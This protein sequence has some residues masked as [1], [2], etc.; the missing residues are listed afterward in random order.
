MILYRY[1][2]KIVNNEVYISEI[3]AVP[4][5]KDTKKFGDVKYDISDN[6][7]IIY[8]Y[9]PKWVVLKNHRDAVVIMHAF[10]TS[11]QYRPQSAF[12]KNFTKGMGVG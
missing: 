4:Y 5:N 12:M 7:D 9:H 2:I 11:N 10:L 8:C 3:D 6:D 1:G